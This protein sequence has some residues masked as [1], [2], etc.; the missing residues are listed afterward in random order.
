MTID[1]LVPHDFFTLGL[2]SYHQPSLSCWDVVQEMYRSHCVG[3]FPCGAKQ[4]FKKLA[5]EGGHHPF[6]LVLVPIASS[7]ASRPECAQ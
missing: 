7:L 2:R 6:F 1:R 5:V 4:P 3:V